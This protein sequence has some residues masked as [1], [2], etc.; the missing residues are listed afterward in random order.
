VL[1]PGWENSLGAQAEVATARAL[2]LRVLPYVEV[3]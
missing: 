1:L 3:A 2:S